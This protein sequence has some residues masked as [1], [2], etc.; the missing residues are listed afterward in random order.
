MKSKMSQKFNNALWSVFD[1]LM[2]ATGKKFTLP[3]NLDIQVEKIVIQKRENSKSGQFTEVIQITEKQRI[4]EVIKFFVERKSGWLRPWD[5]VPFG[6][7]SLS[8]I[9]SQKNNAYTFFVSGGVIVTFSQ[10]LQERLW[11]FPQEGDYDRLASIL[12]LESYKQFNEK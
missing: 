11:R 12:G 9:D 8:L 3:L 5:T 7:F 10:Q 4:Q 2:R 6:V 1:D